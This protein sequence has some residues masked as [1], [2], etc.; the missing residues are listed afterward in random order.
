MAATSPMYCIYS[1]RI[2]DI[3]D[4]LAEFFGRVGGESGKRSFLPQP[5]YQAICFIEKV[6][7][8]IELW[9]HGQGRG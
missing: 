9:C 5:G 4:I 8:V 3:L 7:Q 1:T 2:L 6:A